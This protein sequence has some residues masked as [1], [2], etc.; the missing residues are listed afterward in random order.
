MI[1]LR[2][3]V[4]YAEDVTPSSSG[5][6]SAGQ[7]SESLTSDDMLLQTTHTA[8][9]FDQSMLNWQGLQEWA[10]KTWA[11]RSVTC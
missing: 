4:P 11:K 9:L 8:S 7:S 2:V 5:C 10:E 1:L 6:L 3:Q